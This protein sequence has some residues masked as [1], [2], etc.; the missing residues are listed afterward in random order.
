MSGVVWKSH[1]QTFYNEIALCHID[2][3]LPFNLVKGVTSIKMINLTKSAGGEQNYHVSS[4]KALMAD[5][6]WN[7]NKLPR[8]K[9]TIK[10]LCTLLMCRKCCFFDVFTPDALTRNSMH[11]HIHKTT[12]S[13]H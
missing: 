7:T 1:R 4:V 3:T 2:G 11:I 5:L 8:F 9:K 13:E 12:F 6:C 10:L